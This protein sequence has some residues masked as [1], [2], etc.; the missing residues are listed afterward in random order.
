VA[1][2]GGGGAVCPRQGGGAVARFAGEAEDLPRARVAALALERRRGSRRP[3]AGAGAVAR[4]RGGAGGLQVVLFAGLPIGEPVVAG[5][6][7]V[8]NSRA[9]VER[10]YDRYR[11]GEMGALAPSFTPNRR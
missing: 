9:D 4:L 1:P 7:F 11:R 5:G 3:S 10:A 8:M 6:P 2:W